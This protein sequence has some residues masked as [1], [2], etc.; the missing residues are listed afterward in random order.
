MRKPSHRNS[1]GGPA[2]CEG[3]RVPGNPE[4]REPDFLFKTNICV[5]WSVCV[6]LFL[7]RV[8][9]CTFLGRLGF[10]DDIL[11]QFTPT[12]GLDLLRIP[13]LPRVGF[14]LMYCHQ[15]NPGSR[16]SDGN[17]KI[18]SAQLKALRSAL[19]ELDLG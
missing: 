14:F 16:C 10:L 8:C 9:V 18:R 2:L 3:Q 7:G 4:S 13:I 1:A 17:A 19:E 11:G 15:R 6:C 5:F 12:G